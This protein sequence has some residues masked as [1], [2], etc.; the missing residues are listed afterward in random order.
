MRPFFPPNSD[1]A[2]AKYKA[3]WFFHFAFIGEFICC[4]FEVCY[5]GV[6]IETSL[7]IVLLGPEVNSSLS[8]RGTDRYDP[9]VWRRENH[10][11]THFG[12]LKDD[13][14]RD[15]MLL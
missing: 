14:G 4:K 6:M 3:T 9:P 13:A 8:E 11:S 12:S 1:E 15:W 2:E 5:N 10:A 7:W